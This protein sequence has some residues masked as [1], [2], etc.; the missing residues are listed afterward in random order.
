[1]SDELRRVLWPK[2]HRPDIWAIVDAAQDQQIYWTLTNSFLPH[3]CLFAGALPQ[4][5]EMAA[6]YLVQLDPEDKFT[7]YLAKNLRTHVA[8][9]LQCDAS[10][11]E[12]RRHLR[13]FLT[14]KDPSG[15]RMLFR[16][17]DPRVMRVY[18][19]T[20][21][22]LELQTVFGPVKSFWAV[23]E[24]LNTLTQFAFRGKHLEVTP[25]QLGAA[26]T[27]LA[28]V[29]VTA[30]SLIPVPKG[31]A[32]QTRVPV[33]LQGAGRGGTLRRSSPAIGFFRTLSA[34]E[35]LPFLDGAYTIPAAQLEPDVTV[36]A[37]AAS[38][39]EVLLTLETPAGGKA[40][41]KLRAVEL[42]LEAGGAAICVGTTMA[43]RRRL[44]VGPVRYAGRLTLRASKGLTLYESP[45]AQQGHTLAEGFAFD[46]PQ[47]AV[48]FWLE[49]DKAGPG[50]VE[51][52]VEGSQIVG[53]AAEVT[54]VTIG[55][56]RESP[57]TLLA[58]LGDGL[59]LVAETV[60]AGIGI[61][62]SVTRS[63]D[64]GDDAR[65]FSLNA[66][67][68]LEGAKLAADATGTFVVRATAG[69]ASGEWGGPSAS[70]EVNLVHATLVENRSTI[71]GRFCACAR[72]A[73][74][75]QF[76]LHCG[77]GGA[78]LEADVA[79]TGGGPDARRGV[80][81]IRIGWVHRVA[82]DNSGVR[83]KGGAKRQAGG[84]FALETEAGTALT[85]RATVAPSS[86]WPVQDGGAIEQIWRY[87]DGESYLAFWSTD[88]MPRVGTLLKI[89]WSFTGDYACNATK[90][91]KIIVPARL[92]STG[93]IV[94]PALKDIEELH[95][96]QAD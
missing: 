17:Y 87:L 36:Y 39:G 7:D 79:L 37:E 88:T 34:P 53:A 31:T 6:P 58:G 30:Q 21:T 11:H 72:E 18:L 82:S 89:G 45:T 66:V 55:V 9:F 8:L 77:N 96:R 14:V 95:D 83:Y 19:P 56:E 50:R 59:P 27:E 68:T 33:L 74:T 15:R 57:V 48:S 61:Q 52:L 1:M 69:D 23:S 91:T 13:T 12:L 44:E 94:L 16:Y 70:M 64:D 38:G 60:P 25:R 43:T 84:P 75:D 47:E 22:T 73:G 63:E 54:V 86:S 85:V 51:L 28:T 46:A 80:E 49:G 90:T 81:A 2:G 4:A 76:R 5:L 93:T 29:I 62:W 42:T 20:C 92:A 26:E 35:E 3:S 78:H 71:N 24:E 67:P 10:L 41:T 40:E 32:G 65:K